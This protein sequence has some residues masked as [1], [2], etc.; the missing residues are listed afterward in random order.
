MEKILKM[1]LA[2]SLCTLS[3]IPLHLHAN[4]TLNDEYLINKDEFSDVKA[5][6]VSSQ[7]SS[8]TIE[9]TLD[10]DNKTMW[11]SDW[12]DNSQTLPQYITYDLGAAYDLTDITFLPR[13]GS[14][15]NGDIVELKVYTGLTTSSLAYV[16]TY[17]FEYTKSGLVN[18]TEFKRVS[19]TELARYVKLE[20][21]KSC[22]DSTQDKF[23]SMAEV[24]FYGTQSQVEV[25]TAD[26][27]VLQ[28][29]IKEAEALNRMDY[30]TV[31][32]NIFLDGLSGARTAFDNEDITQVDVDIAA[33]RLQE[34]MNQLVK[35]TDL[36]PENLI[37]KKADDGV[38]ALS[39]TSQYES[40]IKE[41]TLDYNTGTYWHTNFAERDRYLPQSIT[42]DL[43]KSYDLTDI[44]FLPRQDSS[45]NG[46]ITECSV[47][48]GEELDDLIFIEQ[49]TFEGGPGGLIGRNDFIRMIID[50]TGR[51]VKITVTKSLASSTNNKHA[52][53]SEIRFY[54]NEADIQASL[55]K[56]KN[57]LNKT[58]AEIEALNEE[59]YSLYSWNEL[60]VVYEEA[61]VKMDQSDVL[62]RE[63][64]KL[65]TLLNNK[66]KSLVERSALKPVLEEAE[67]LLSLGDDYTPASF[68]VLQG[69][70][71]EALALYESTTVYTLANVNQQITQL[72]MAMNQLVE[73][74]KAPAMVQNVKVRQVSYKEITLTWDPVR[75]ASAYDVYRKS[76]KD[77]SEFEYLQTVKLPY[78]KVSGL[79]TG[80][81][82]TFYVIAKNS[83][84]SSQPSSNVIAKTALT[85]KVKLAIEQV[86]NTKFKLSWN[87]ID[88]ATRY[89]VYR[90]R[91]SDSY[92]KVLTLG[93]DDVSYTTSSLAGGNYR[94]IVRAARY[95]SKDR[96]MTN[97][98]NSV[99][100]QVTLEAPVMK[101]TSQSK[102]VKVS[103]QSVE[104]V[105]NYEVYMATSKDGKYI[106]Q[107]TTTKTSCE[108]KTLTSGKTYY[109]KVCGY[110][111][112][113]EVDVYSP[114]S[115]VKAVKV[116]S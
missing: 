62:P 79:V 24:R 26:K 20:V 21:T 112:Y 98:S 68:N 99:Q 5:I 29:L 6:D 107:V 76:Y 63:L 42:F 45:Y 52:S 80:K 25:T 88:G 60:N 50:A 4:D 37:N 108:I 69:T 114:Y 32:W 23:A 110:K 49:Y 18:R 57:N 44:T 115:D 19:L 64:D 101:V 83:V 104:G 77:N 81:N 51:Y 102:A 97:N 103:W 95:D 86:S 34:V 10:Y 71:N 13:Q 53:I 48:V 40:N 70:Y 31:S 1:L 84:G 82:Y 3:V 30:T 96:V 73:V 56:A 46:D 72:T 94:F 7:Y 66:M 85:G 22:A 65:N 33:N 91:N 58:F 89:I 11:H 93:K 39:T 92:R 67:N 90:K 36:N 54:G 113:N 59:S 75:K 61:K 74:L 14:S 106:K 12:A 43:G 105:T 100:A 87:Q 116:Q 17:E 109:F 8:E 16:D 28:Q 47:Y 27:T 2:L 35:N 55:E 15:C 9:N 78:A 111:T 38:V 41:Y